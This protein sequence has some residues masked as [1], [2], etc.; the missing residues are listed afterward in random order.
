MDSIPSWFPATTL[1]WAENMLRNRSPTKAALIQVTEPTP[2]NPDPQL[3]TL[4]YSEL[5]V[6]V[7]KVVNWFLF[8]G[9]QPGDRVASYSSNSIETVVACLAATALGAIWVSAAADF[10]PQGVLERFE[11]VK[12]KVLFGIDSVV[13]NAKSHEQIPKL[14]SV[15][16]G[17]RALSL[18]P[19]KVVVVPHEPNSSRAGWESNWLSWTDILSSTLS[20]EDV[21]KG[22]PFW[23]GPFDH[24][25]W[26]LFS[27]G[28]TGK[29]KPI[30]HRAGGMLLQS[31]K[32]LII[33]GDFVPEDV[34]FYYTTTG[35]MMWNFLVGG[36]SIGLTLVLYDG[37]PLRDPSFLWQLTDKIGITV[38]GTS[39]KYLEQLEKQYKPK[40]HHSL[41]SLRLVLSTGSP[42]APS[43]FDYVY[44]H[45]SRSVCLGSITGGTDICSLF[46]GM[47]TSLPVYRGEIQCRMLGMSI[48]TCNDEGVPLPAGTPGDL[49][50]DKHFPCQPLGFWP[51]PGYGAD[52]DTKK[53]QDRYMEAYY[54]K[55][56]GVWH[57][58][59]HILITKSRDGNGGGVLMLGR[60]DGVLNP[61]GIR[62]G[63]AEIYQ[64]LESCFSPLTAKSPDEI[65]LDSLVVA[66]PV[67]GGADER[68]IL[69]LQ[70]AEG[71]NLSENL[72]NRVKTEIRIRRSPR[73][74]PARILQVHD[75]PHT[76]NGKKVEVP[77]KK[78]IRGAPITSLNLNTLRNPESLEEYVKLGDQLRKEVDAISP[79]GHL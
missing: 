58:G 77:V 39:A 16:D 35:W 36:L 28:T 26:V 49:I 66:Q 1:N 37:S 34:Y 23:R 33:C 10:A 4:T 57:H 69:F 6:A 21:R 78:L 63:S 20:D 14:S 60:S 5:Y 64:V 3:R 9:I 76:L 68:V 56:K 67:R 24:P 11:Q 19:Q 45:I 25:L 32:E 40:D 61:G 27:S 73:H 44:N 48:R 8:I 43:Q 47:N 7:H 62:F 13:Y 75:I 74:V 22:I 54:E 55:F 29:P 46:C 79:L 70:L 42:L 72:L 18:T 71:Q 15:L 52:A 51:L 38:F 31:A 2:Q 53:A 65:I 50:C 59:D 41:K 30:V 12:P 17:L